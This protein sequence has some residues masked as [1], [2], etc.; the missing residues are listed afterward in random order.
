MFISNNQLLELTI[1]NHYFTKPITSYSDDLEYNISVSFL[2]VQLP[3]EQNLTYEDI[4]SDKLSSNILKTEKRAIGDY[5]YDA[6]D[7]IAINSKS[8]LKKGFCSYIIS[9]PIKDRSIELITDY[10]L[11]K[12][13]GFDFI[14][15]KENA[16]FSNYASSDEVDDKIQKANPFFSF[17]NAC[18]YIVKFTF[19]II[20][21]RIFNVKRI[22]FKMN[23]NP[24]I[25]MKLHYKRNDNLSISFPMKELI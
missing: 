3:E 25:L 15:R 7:R 17:L 18:A 19:S 14:I 2:V 8:L 12:Q 6:D 23:N 22:S 5:T 11:D 24:V 10:R 20:Y 9:I 1:E 13:F 21:N 16:V 4:K